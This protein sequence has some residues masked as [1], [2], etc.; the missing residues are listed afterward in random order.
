[1]SRTLSGLFLVGAVNR[2][3][4][5]KRTNP[6]ESPDKSGKS[7]KNPE[8]PNSVLPLLVFF[9][10]KWQG[11]LPKKQGLFIPTEPLKSLEKRGETLEKTRSF[12]AGEKKQGIL[13]KQGK[14]GQGKGQKRTNPDRETPPFEPPRL[15]AL[16]ILGVASFEAKA[17]TI[18]HTQRLPN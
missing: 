4:K 5:R 13:K 10:G 2:P 14:E 12:L 7:R 18:A 6:G 11:K 15:A 8:V 3:G 1:M 16:D 9:F 17:S